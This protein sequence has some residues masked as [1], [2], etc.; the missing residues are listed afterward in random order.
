LRGRGIKFHEILQQICE[1]I[2]GWPKKFQKLPFFCQIF[3]F[4]AKK[5]N[6]IRGWGGS[7]LRIFSGEG[8]GLLPLM[9]SCVFRRPSFI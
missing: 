9:E 4:L 5:K 3:P 6:K 7:R 8:Q 2:E 1:N